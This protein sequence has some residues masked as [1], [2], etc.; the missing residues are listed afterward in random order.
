[1]V[2]TGPAARTPAESPQPPNALWRARR[3]IPGEQIRLAGLASLFEQALS[4]ADGSE[5]AMSKSA[6]KPRKQQKQKPQKTLK[7][8]RSEK[9]AAKKFGSVALLPADK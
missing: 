2:C 1:M 4:G 8:R 7:E 6:D 3:R 5:V 9:R